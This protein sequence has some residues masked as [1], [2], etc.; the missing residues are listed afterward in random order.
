MFPLDVITNEPDIDKATRSAVE[1]DASLPVASW[2]APKPRIAD[3]RI[4][5][6]DG[7]SVHRNIFGSPMSQLGLASRVTPVHTARRN[8]TR[9]GGGPS[10]VGNQ[11]LISSHHK[12]LRSK[13]TVVSVAGKPEQDSGRQ[14]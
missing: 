8:C 13:A 1:G 9:D 2:G 5:A 4:L 3:Y 7:P 12:L 6:R 11:V 10:G 14:D